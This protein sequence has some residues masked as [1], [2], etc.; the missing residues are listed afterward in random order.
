MYVYSTWVQ[1][2]ASVKRLSQ[3]ADRLS[4]S[5]T[6]PLRDDAGGSLWLN[7]IDFAERSQ[8]DWEQSTT[9]G[10][11]WTGLADI[12]SDGFGDHL[13][14]ML[15]PSRALLVELRDDVGGLFRQLGISQEPVTYSFR[16][17]LQP[18][19]A[20]RGIVLRSVRL[21]GDL[22]DIVVQAGTV[23]SLREQLAGLPGEITGVTVDI[24][25][26]PVTVFDDGVLVF[27]ETSKNLSI[28]GSMRAL[29]ATLPKPARAW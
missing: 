7:P 15:A 13:V 14:G 27:S 24:L 8:S 12:S 16:S 11:R 29:D 2:D 1:T 19:L 18:A 6:P 10:V 17:L 4:N 9:S 26:N 3:L 20:E 21:H 28:L 25:D 22:G 23:G 5:D